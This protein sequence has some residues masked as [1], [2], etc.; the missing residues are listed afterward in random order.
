MKST[1][2]IIVVIFSMMTNIVIAKSVIL[3]IEN[4]ASYQF[5]CYQIKVLDLSTNDLSGTWYQYPGQIKKIYYGFTAATRSDYQVNNDIPFENENGDFE[6][7]GILSPKFAHNGGYKGAYVLLN[8]T[9][10]IEVPENKNIVFK[11]EFDEYFG[12]CFQLQT[13]KFI[14]AKQTKTYFVDLLK[15]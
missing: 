7:A 11:L 12:N 3:P 10:T 5:I 13:D 4:W 8:S 2:S 9:I 1:K 6:L 14:F 15:N